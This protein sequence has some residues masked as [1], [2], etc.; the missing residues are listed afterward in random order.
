MNPKRKTAILGLLAII[1]L[2]LLPLRA[3]AQCALPSDG[4]VGHWKLDE[5]SGSTAADSMAIIGNSTAMTNFS[6]PAAWNSSAGTVDGALDFDGDAYVVMPSTNFGNQFSISLW[7]KP[8]YV[9]DG[10]YALVANSSNG[11]S[12]NGFRLLM[13]YDSSVANIYMETGN[14]STFDNAE[15]PAPNGFVMQQWNHVLVTADRISGVG[16]IYVNG[17]KVSSGDNILTNFNNNGV[18]H[19]GAWTVAPGDFFDGLMDDVRVY[20]RVLSDAEIAALYSIRSTAAA[21]AGYMTYDVKHSRMMYCDGTQWVHAG[22]GAYNPNAVE[23]DG[24]M[25]LQ[26]TTPTLPQNSKALS[27][28]VWVRRNAVG[29]DMNIYSDGNY[30]F[31]ISITSPGEFSIGAYNDDAAWILICGSETAPLNDTS[32]HHILWSFDLSNPAKKNIYVDDINHTPATCAT[33]VDDYFMHIADSLVGSGTGGTTRFDGAMADLWQDFETYIDF[34]IEANRRKF[35]SASGMPMYLGPD[36]SIPTGTVPD[37]FMTG[38]TDTWH[39]NKGTGGGFTET[40]ALTTS[41]SQPGDSLISNTIGGPALENSVFG[42]GY[43]PATSQTLNLGFTPTAGRLLV[44]A[45]SWDKLVTGVTETSGEWTQVAYEASGVSSSGVMYYKVSEGDE[46]SFALTWTNLE[47]PAIWVGE[48]S[49]VVSVSPFDKSVSAD[50][51]DVAV[52]SISPGTTAALAQANEMA[53]AMVG[54]D[55]GTSLEDNR[56]WSNGFKEIF[57]CQNCVDPAVRVAFK[58]VSSTGGVT[59]TYSAADT[60]DQAVAIL[61]TFKADGTESASACSATS[62]GK[63]IYDNTFNV[64]QYCNGA[65]WVAMGPVGGTPPTS[66]LLGYWKLDETSGATA[67]DSAG[68]RDGAWTDG[69][70]NDVTEEAVAGQISGAFNFTG[71][72]YVSISGESAA[73]SINQYTASAWIYRTSDTGLV[74]MIIDNRDGAS[75]GWN[76]TIAAND[77]LRCAYNTTNT[78][79]FVA[80]PVNT[81]WHL[82][83][84]SDGTSVA[85]YVNGVSLDTEL[86]AGS[87]AETTNMAIGTRSW[88]PAFPFTGYIDDVR[89]YNRALSS[90]EIQALYHY[91]LSGG[92]GDVSGNCSN[93][94]APEGRMFYN[95]DF[96][97]MQYCNGER[98]IG[99]GQ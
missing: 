54:I 34:S 48:F 39:T 44:A 12:T 60:G 65:E 31:G 97:V 49:G 9:A 13:Y 20:N 58:N 1:G 2:L 81:W 28:S 57:P 38:T 56:A 42:F 66:G 76:M 73:F 61:A 99:I 32:W 50:S 16:K 43:S 98:W 40:G 96:N 18:W 5:T 90:K 83:C 21:P 91:G 93:P 30:D 68:T 69:A 41:A 89:V 33:W 77:A 92:L 8:D 15:A 79:T 55:T 95:I 3:H 85:S 36:G 62:R 29:T 14:G 7:I 4:L 71:S 53:I 82:A 37:I 24:S 6:I 64:M 27:G 10:L 86:A 26:N 67:D 59:T 23:F 11:S 78:N 22:T 47:E 84:V 52:T 35:R 19:L 74:E 51:A 46:T 45:A 87:I 70:N 80:L 75:D 72:K 94:V 25:H 63:M 88:G 17:V